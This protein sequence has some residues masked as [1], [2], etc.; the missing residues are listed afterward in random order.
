MP[1]E[2]HGPEE[3]LG[4]IFDASARLEQ[5]LS[6]KSRGCMAACRNV[7]FFFSF[8][9]TDKLLSALVLY[10]AFRHPPQPAPIALPNPEPLQGLWSC[11]W[12]DLKP[13]LGALEQRSSHTT[14]WE[15]RGTPWVTVA[16]SE[17]ATGD[18][19]ELF[20]L[21]E[22]AL[23]ALRKDLGFFWLVTPPVLGTKQE[24]RGAVGTRVDATIAGR[25]HREAASDTQRQ[26]Q[27]SAGS[28]GKAR[29]PSPA[30]WETG[31]QTGARACAE[32][33]PVPG[34]GQ[35]CPWCHPL[36]TVTPFHSQRSDSN[37]TLLISARLHVNDLSYSEKLFHLVTPLLLPSRAPDFLLMCLLGSHDD[38]NSSILVSP[39]LRVTAF[40]PNAAPGEKTPGGGEGQ[41]LQSHQLRVFH[42]IMGWLWLQ[43][44]L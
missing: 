30:Q 41:A 12:G 31:G 32:T 25:R 39:P 38:F 35:G 40:A 23:K 21:K 7:V 14:A 3:G 11:F 18:P 24:V 29:R 10:Y 17:K 34:N 27:V 8:W 22:E 42:R 13:L 28:D 4:G 36:H 5:A 33:R 44:P 2:H 1:S 6:R 43:G 20:C 9:V 37:H 15:A 16:Q 19:S 26:H